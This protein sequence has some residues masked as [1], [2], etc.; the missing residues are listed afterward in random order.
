MAAYYYTTT[1]EIPAVYH[2]NQNCEEGRKIKPEN[3]VDTNTIP[4][5]RRRCEVC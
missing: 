4:G 5:G 1:D 3:R 2:D